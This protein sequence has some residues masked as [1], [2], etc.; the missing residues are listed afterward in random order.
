MLKWR[1]FKF[2]AKAMCVSN[3]KTIII[4]SQSTQYR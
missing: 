4:K 3:N 2:F 1:G